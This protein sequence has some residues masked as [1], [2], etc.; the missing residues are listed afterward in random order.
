MFVSSGEYCG[1][2]EG[3]RRYQVGAFVESTELKGM[4]ST[5]ENS[6]LSPT[7]CAFLGNR[8]VWHFSVLILQLSPYLI[9]YA[10]IPIMIGWIKCC[11]VQGRRAAEQDLVALWRWSCS[12]LAV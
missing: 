6:V 8:S 11:L 2:R 1:G 7:R 3:L 10:H 12:S 9:P 5:L 4:G